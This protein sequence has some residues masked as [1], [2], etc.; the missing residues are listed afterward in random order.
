MPTALAVGALIF[1][2]GVFWWGARAA[3][4]RAVLLRTRQFF[5]DLLQVQKKTSFWQRYLTTLQTDL[6]R[7]GLKVDVYRYARYVPIAGLVFIGISRLA[8]GVPLWLGLTMV[9]LLVLLPRQIVAE[10]SNRYV[11]NLRKRLLMDVINPGIHVLHTGSIEDAC[12]EIE[13]ETTSP[14]IRR[15]FKYINELGRA[16]GDMSV[17]KAMMIRAQE[18]HIP[19]FETLAVLTYEGQRYN[20]SL[21]DLWRDTRQALAEKIQTQNAILS[22]I[23]IYRL[24]AIGL[25]LAIVAVAT[26]GY[27]PLHIHGI[28]QIG[29]FITL[30][31]SF[32][33]VSQVAKT[34]NLDG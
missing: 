1:L 25:F 24:I 20:A 30:I 3:E 4:K 18:L 14:M 33:G 23:S 21:P 17:A 2:S 16:P 9:V 31:S 34:T 13:R 28:M 6:N 15:E 11:V 10:L 7:I 27:R 19:E 12:E 32:V 5:G 29:L 8:F 26:V 22:E